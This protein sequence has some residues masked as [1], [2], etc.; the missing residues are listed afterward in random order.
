VYSGYSEYTHTDCTISR[1][2][3]GD[4]FLVGLVT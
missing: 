3:H 1:Q 4:P 2:K